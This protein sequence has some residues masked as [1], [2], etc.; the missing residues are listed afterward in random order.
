MSSWIGIAHTHGYSGP[1]LDMWRPH[2]I[3]KHLRRALVPA[4]EHSCFCTVQ[5]Y[6]E[7]GRRV[8]KDYGLLGQEPLHFMDCNQGF[9]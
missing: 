3:E 4:R 7:F 2:E 8:C 1:N 6:P 9:C 5:Q